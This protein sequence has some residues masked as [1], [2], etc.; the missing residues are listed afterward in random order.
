MVFKLII[1]LLMVLHSITI[2]KILKKD[3]KRNQQNK[4]TKINI[5]NL[6]NNFI[7]MIKL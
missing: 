7:I 1:S 6:E 5:Q 3:L 2:L 4:M